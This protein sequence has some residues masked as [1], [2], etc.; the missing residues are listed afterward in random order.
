MQQNLLKQEDTV[1]NSNPEIRGAIPLPYRVN[2]GKEKS[3]NGL[4]K[5]QAVRELILHCASVRC[6]GLGYRAW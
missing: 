5:P 2:A 3:H 1:E 4:P 6:I